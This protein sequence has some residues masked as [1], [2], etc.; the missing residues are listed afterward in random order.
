MQIMNTDTLTTLTKIKTVLEI[1]EFT[2][3]TIEETN[4]LIEIKEKL[5]NS[6]NLDY[7]I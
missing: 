5:I 1:L 7:N 2:K 3:L 4:K 6:I